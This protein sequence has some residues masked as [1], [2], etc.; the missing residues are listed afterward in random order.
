MN[1]ID[2]MQTAKYTSIDRFYLNFPPKNKSLKW[3]LKSNN[4]SDFA[5]ERLLQ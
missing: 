4:T 1:T 5:R 2:V 3:A